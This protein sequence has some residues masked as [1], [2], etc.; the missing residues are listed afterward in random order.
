MFNI[1]HGSM[2]IVSV[3]LCWLIMQRAIKIALFPY[4][5][6][7]LTMS[8]DQDVNLRLANELKR[9]LKATTNIIKNEMMRDETTAA[10][11]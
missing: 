4:A 7:I 8:H 2:F 10:Q 11:A 6:R 5:S 1:I 9:L 3:L